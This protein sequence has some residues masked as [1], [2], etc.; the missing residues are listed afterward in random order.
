VNKVLEPLVKDHGIAI[1]DPALSWLI[2]IAI[3]TD[4]I[5]VMDGTGEAIIFN[6]EK[7]NWEATDGPAEKKGQVWYSNTSFR[8][9]YWQ[10]RQ[11]NYSPANRDWQPGTGSVNPHAAHRGQPDLPIGDEEAGEGS[12]WEGYGYAGRMGASG[13][14]L[15]GADTEIA[16]DE[17]RGPGK[18]TE[19]GW[20]DKEI[21]DEIEGVK[22]K[23]G[24]QRED[25]IIYVFNN[26]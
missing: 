19:Y 3:G 18:M 1:D 17:N 21:E 22:K 14:S 11:T 15:S 13:A 8:N 7:G 12:N 26:A 20:F 16:T 5:V 24:Q 6:E 23:T 10:H 9:V 25:A 2:K 4:K